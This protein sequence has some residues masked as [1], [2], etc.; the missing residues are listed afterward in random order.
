MSDLKFPA[1][2]KYAKSDEWVRVEDGIATIGIS[3]YA[4]DSLN[5]IVYIELKSK[6]D[7]L[8]VGDSIGEVESVKASS[9]MYSPVA[10]EII[11]S[12]EALSD[13]PEVINSDPYGIGWMVKIKISDE[14]KLS[15][16][17]DAEAYK[18]YCESR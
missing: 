5:D 16:L 2:L 6:G 8:A 4:Q 17:M 18:T 13:D 14:G 3:D 15:S 9:E 11:E 7:V 1:D 12:N 10:G